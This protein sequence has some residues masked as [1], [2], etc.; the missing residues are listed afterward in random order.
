MIIG[1]TDN[2]IVRNI[3]IY[4]KDLKGFDHLS[5]YRLGSMANETKYPAKIDI[6]DARPKTKPSHIYLT[7]DRGPALQKMPYITYGA[8]VYPQTATFGP[9]TASAT[10]LTTLNPYAATT[11]KGNVRLSKKNEA[12]IEFYPIKIHRCLYMYINILAVANN[13]FPNCPKCCANG[14]RLGLCGDP[15]VCP[16]KILK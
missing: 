3:H 7:N 9:T 15:K 10:V 13:T 4:D 16:G 8:N 1:L 6:T 14:C 11:S 12:S 2:K 5:E